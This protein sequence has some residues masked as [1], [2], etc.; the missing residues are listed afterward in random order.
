MICG[1]IQTELQSV[2]LLCSVMGSHLGTVIMSGVDD[3]KCYPHTDVTLCWSS[4]LLR[5]LLDLGL[6]LGTCV[7]EEDERR[8]IVN[9]NDLII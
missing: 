8:E 5:P 7:Y 4:C 1:I 9:L 2:H 3:C 6:D